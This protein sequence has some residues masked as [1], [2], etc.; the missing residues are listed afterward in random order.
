MSF[1]TTCGDFLAEVKQMRDSAIAQAVQS[2]LQTEHE[3][4]KAQLVKARDEFVVA[5][6]QAC[7]KLVEQIKAECEKKCQA[8]IS[9]T[10][11]AI[12][13][14]RTSVTATAEASAKT[15]YNNFILG[16]AK[17]IDETKIN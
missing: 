4:Y 16:V 9:A 12:A 8:K 5:E 14:N 1:K 11:T 13:E 3:P 6:K 15:E 10:E 17:L 2:A 7:E